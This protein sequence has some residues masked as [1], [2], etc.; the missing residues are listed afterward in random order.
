[1]IMRNTETPN[2]ATRLVFFNEGD[3]VRLKIPQAPTMLVKGV[4]KDSAASRSRERL[5]GIRCCW[6]DAESRYHEETFNTKDLEHVF[7]R[8]VMAVSAAT[9]RETGE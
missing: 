1:M 8:K 6:F 2:P 5:K 3:Q 9:F 7:A 4:V